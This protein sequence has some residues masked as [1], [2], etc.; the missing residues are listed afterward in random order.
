VGLV[1]LPAPLRQEARCKAVSE[2]KRH[3][4]RL[5]CDLKK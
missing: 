2:R 4:E 3:G 1:S 5:C